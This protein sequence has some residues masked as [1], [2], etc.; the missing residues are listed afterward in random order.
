M[1]I[2]FL[3]N[4]N[5]NEKGGLF[6][7]THNRIKTLVDNFRD[8]EVQ[9]YSLVK[10]E[11]FFMKIV[12]KIL[13]KP[14]A[15]EFLN[16]RFEYDGVTY[17]YIYFKE[18]LLRNISKRLGRDAYFKK[19]IK[20]IKNI[21]EFDII[22]AH[23]G[24]SPGSL[25]YYISKKYCI[26]YILTLH[27]SDVH[28]LPFKRKGIRKILIRNLTNSNANFF[29]SQKLMDI[30]KELGWNDNKSFVSYNAIN[31][32]VFAPISQSEIELLKKKMKYNN[33]VVGYV[34]N[35]NKT[36]RADWLIRIFGQIQ[37]D[38]PED[39]TFLIIGDGELK[40]QIKKEHIQS[41]ID[42]RI[43]GRVP[44]EKLRYYYSIMDCLV[45]PSKNE[46]LGNVI[47]E[48]QA[49][50]VPVV[51]TNTGGI[52][53]IIANKKNLVRN[54]EKSIIIDFSNKVAQILKKKE[55]NV[56]KVESWLDVVTRELDILKKINVI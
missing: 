39:I 41:N 52:P 11:S 48:A 51:A 34:G 43:I 31:N 36:K 32:K 16:D 10:Y 23:W 4:L 37:R 24:D 2:L 53:E 26:P 46:G 28:T 25:A 35:L 3:V 27:G 54:D 9:I 12:K 7:A 50:G 49:C 30:A 1:K 56:L 47:L 22:S 29:V 42:L 45:L 5:E 14:T 15:K 44:Q 6:V 13:G 38:F 20:D 40:E 19:I 17:K 33:Y 18:T 8:Y 55:R 21:D